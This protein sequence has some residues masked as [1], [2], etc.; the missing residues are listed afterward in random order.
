MGRLLSD[1][2][3]KMSSKAEKG[4]QDPMKIL[5][6]STHDTALAGLCSTLDVFDERYVTPKQSSFLIHRLFA[7]GPPSLPQSHL[8]CSRRVLQKIFLNAVFSKPSCHHSDSLRP[9]RSTVCCLIVPYHRM[10]IVNT[11]PVV[12][13]RYQNRNLTLPLCSEEGN[14]LP[15][16]PE[17]CT[18][19]A[20]QARVK[21]LTP[22]DWEKECAPINRTSKAA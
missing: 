8:S 6:H 10:L 20:F 4:E 12:R 21:E 9:P 11:T 19:E 15:G 1:L 22:V 3:R 7:A 13:M 2:S 16:S 17:F 14:H 5:V 18:L